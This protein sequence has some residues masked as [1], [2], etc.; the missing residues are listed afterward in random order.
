M[1]LEKIHNPQDIRKLNFEELALLAQEIRQRIIQVISLSGGHLAS[2]LGAVELA[3]ALHYCLDTPKDK[4]VW[5][6]GHQSYAHKILTSRNKDFT[7]LRQYEGLSGFPSKNESAYDAFTTGHSS[8]AISLAL[9]L[10]CSRDYLA[11]E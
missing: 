4:I 5:D 6:V 11:K 8:T 7:T 10:A 3:L 1:F 9:G 2:S